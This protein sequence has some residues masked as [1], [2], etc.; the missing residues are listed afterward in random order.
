VSPF[1]ALLALFGLWFY[2]FRS[3]GRRYRFLG[4]LF[5]LT[6]LLFAVAGARSYYTAPLYPML[7]A[8]GS[9]LMGNWLARLRPLWSCLIYGVQ[10][11]AIA[12][13]LIIGILLFLPV[14]PIGSPIWKVTA[15]IYDQFREEVGWPELAQSV[16]NVYNSL[17][18]DE[19]AR[20]GI[21]TGNYGEAGALGL[22]GPALGLPRAM[23]LTNSFWYRSFDK[24]QPQTVILVGF[25]PDEGRELFESCEVAAKN[26]NPFNV[27]NE[28]SRD[29]PDILLCRNLK[30]HWPDYWAN[31]RRFG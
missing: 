14:V 11:A 19:R 21:L 24:R 4:W 23:S 26:T 7:L 6:F 12:A 17:P 8:S 10:W 3:E 31:H 30:Q 29:H 18:P 22:Y 16:A 2:F 1:T 15:K 13:G 25:D 28:E 5:A 20:T 9:V 27:V